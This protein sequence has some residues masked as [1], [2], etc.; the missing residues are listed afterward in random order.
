MVALAEHKE[1]FNS[2]IT[3]NMLLLNNVDTWHSKECCTIMGLFFGMA[4]ECTMNK[5]SLKKWEIGHSHVMQILYPLRL[6]TLL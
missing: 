3:Y 1:Y 2:Q 4:F 6:H 5:N